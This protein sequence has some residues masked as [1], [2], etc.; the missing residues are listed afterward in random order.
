MAAI[1]ASVSAFAGK[2]V[3]QAP[4][5]RAKAPK[6]VVIRASAQND[7]ASKV[8]YFAEPKRLHFCEGRAVLS[9]SRS[10]V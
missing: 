2:A 9:T 1:S 8:L 7:A 5:I 3:C 4:Q 10:R 6:A